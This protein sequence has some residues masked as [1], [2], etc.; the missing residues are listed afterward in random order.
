VSPTPLSVHLPF[1][2]EIL[3][4]T[5]TPAKRGGKP[6]V[7]EG[8]WIILQDQNLIVQRE[9]D[10]PMLPRGACPAGLDAITPPLWLGTWQDTPCW[11]ATLPTDAKLPAGLHAET[12][13]P[14]RGTRLPDELL[15][16]GGMS[17]QAVWWESTSGH[18]PRCGERTERI[19]GE[20]GK[21]CP[22]CRYEHYPH[23]HPATIVLVRDG[24]RV[25]LTR[26]EGW[27]PNRYALVAGFVDNGESLEGCVAREIKEEVGVD[28]KDITYVGSQNWPFPSQVMIGFVATYAGGDLVID[29][30]ELE[31]A[32]WFPCNTL[33]G[34]PSR[35]SISRF[36]IDN[37]AQP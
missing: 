18:C 21:R 36:I 10:T 11:V 16:L 35:H 37:Y 27:A 23:L 24:N 2:R 15:S 3:G 29:R 28:V 26:K 8:H 34:L 14:M 6:A 33:P 25:L 1:N 7:T 32:R 17:L 19:D 12:V 31:D 20:W 4:A 13:V 5:F 9:G 30:D 22:R